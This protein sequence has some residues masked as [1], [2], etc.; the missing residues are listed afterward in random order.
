MANLTDLKPKYRLLMKTYPYSSYDWSPGAVLKN[1]LREA[2]LAVVTTAA[3]HLPNQPAF[4]EAIKGGDVSYRAIPANA[5]LSSLRIAH[6]SDAF[7]PA[8][9]EADKNLALPIGSL[10]DLVKEEKLGSVSTR[11]FSFMGS[12]LAPARL[13]ARTAPQVAETL[14]EDGVDVVL[15]TP[16]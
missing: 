6:K 3:F 15:L 4:D 5:D 2:R 9:I 10:L 7:D 14:R 12:I 16:V 11:H 8:G 1:P 13:V